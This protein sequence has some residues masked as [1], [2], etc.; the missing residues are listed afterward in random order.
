MTKVCFP[1]K[2]ELILAPQLIQPTI[3]SKI[4]QQLKIQTDKL[5]KP[6]KQ[7]VSQTKSQAAKL[8]KI[9]NLDDKQSLEKVQDENSKNNLK[10]FNIKLIR[11]KDKLTL[12]SENQIRIR[13]YST[14]IQ[15]NRTNNLSKSSNKKVR[16]YEKVEYWVISQIDDQVGNYKYFEPIKLK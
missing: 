3:Q 6:I 1:S 16:F 12:K 2:N 9:C 13:S 15:T 5:I 10:R 4:V 8:L 7:Q 11:N 14:E